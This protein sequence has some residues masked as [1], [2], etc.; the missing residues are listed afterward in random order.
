MLWLCLHFPRL[1][2][3]ALGFG[4]PLD[5]VTDQRGA[6][7]WLI[8]AA[9]GAGIG[10]PLGAALSLQPGLRAHARSHKAEQAALQQ[11]AHWIYRYGSPVHA[12]MRDLAEV[13]RVPQALLW[14]E[15]AA[16]LRLFGS[17]RAM[18]ERLRGDLAELQQH[19]QLA[20]APT[21]AASAL[22]AC[23]QDGIAIREPAQLQDRLA[24]WPTAALPW[25]RAQLDALQGVGLRRIGDLL[26]VP[27]AAFARRFGA[28]RLRELDQLCGRAAEPG[29]AIVPST[30]FRR[31]FDLAA[32]IEQ[33][34]AL[35][36]PLR[37]LAFELQAWLRARDV[38]LRAVR[39]LCLHAQQRRSSFVLRF[40]DAHR[41]GSRIFDALRERLLRAPLG[42]AV[43]ALELRAEDI[44][45]TEVPQ[46]DLFEA[47]DAGGDWTR[48]IERVAARLGESALW[49]P[50]IHDEYRPER[51]WRRADANLP[52]DVPHRPRPLW[53]LRKPLP[54]PTPDLPDTPPERIESGWW[55][56]ADQR[57]DYHDIEW[58]HARAWVYRERDSER[59]F[60]HGLWA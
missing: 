45:E 15:I 42:A 8:T 29:V 23:L 34:E 22:F 12:E 4:D 47:A 19:A 54:L 10:T 53:L 43:R 32:E 3:E 14:V 41:D 27:R 49:T 48:A 24:A 20:V 6:S 37:R 36:F 18:R 38:G 13:G 39:L 26:A 58:Q 17:Y 30:G 52:L 16:S 5:V 25:P 50:A 46:T 7:R 44:A 9:P 31:R 51:A 56:D 2:V 28:A 33:V 40:G 1:P 60:L 21:R 57:R 59:W 11:L 35:L 55:D